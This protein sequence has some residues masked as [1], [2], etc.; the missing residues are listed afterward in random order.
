MWPSSQRASVKE[1]LCHQDKCHQVTLLTE[2]K[3]IAKGTKGV[4]EEDP[5]GLFSQ[6]SDQIIKLLIEA[7]DGN[8]VM[9]THIAKNNEF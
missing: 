9:D 2:S 6:L 5:K 8:Q 4:S 7:S 1:S 3:V